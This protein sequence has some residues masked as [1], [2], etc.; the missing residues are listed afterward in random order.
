MKEPV[1]GQQALT[2]EVVVRTATGDDLDAVQEVGRRTWP[3]TYDGIFED[4]LVPLILD[5][6]W[7]KQAL[8]PSIRSGRTLV[9]ELAGRVVGM[10]SYAPRGRAW[11]VWRLYVVPEAQRRGVGALLLAEILTQARLLERQVLLSYTDGN[12]SAHAFACSQGF[13]VMRREPQRDG[14]DLIWMS[15][16]T[17]ASDPAGER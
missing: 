3:A 17:G 12:L 2:G 11:A 4:G 1:T 16:P 9:A 10:A 8:T 7:T 15:R 13:T 6:Q 5:K 14:P